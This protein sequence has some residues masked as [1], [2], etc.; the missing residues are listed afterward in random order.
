MLIS[1]QRVDR[2]P[3]IRIHLHPPHRRRDWLVVRPRLT[4]MDIPWN[5]NLQIDF[6]DSVLRHRHRDHGCATS[7]RL[8]SDLAVV[9]IMA[10][11]W[12][13]CISC[14]DF[15]GAHLQLRGRPQISP[16]WAVREYVGRQDVPQGRGVGFERCS[17]VFTRRFTGWQGMSRARTY[18]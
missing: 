16:I 8:Q 18:P 5:P 15:G 17:V 6:L 9:E 2:C 10:S 7:H 12:H 4:P 13:V 11:G 3:R 14:G 1:I